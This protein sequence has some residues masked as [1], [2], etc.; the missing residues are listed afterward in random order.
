MKKTCLI[1]LIL[2]VMLG[3][4]PA[5]NAQVSVNQAMEHVIDH[6]D[7]LAQEEKPIVKTVILDEEESDPEVPRNK[8]VTIGLAVFGLALVIIFRMLRKK[9]RIK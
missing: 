5:V 1:L 8:W 9:K 4:N 7:S 2:F 6:A 3:S